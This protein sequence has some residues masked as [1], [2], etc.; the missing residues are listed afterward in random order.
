MYMSITV[1]FPWIFDQVPPPHQ[2]RLFSLYG[3]PASW[4]RFDA[5]GVENEQQIVKGIEESGMV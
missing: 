4:N 5:T 3:L 2:R 1:K